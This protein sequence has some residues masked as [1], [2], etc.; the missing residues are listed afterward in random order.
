MKFATALRIPKPSWIMLFNLA[1][2]AVL[3]MVVS[4]KVSHDHQSQIDSAVRASH[5]LV[6][7]VISNRDLS[8]NETIA[9]RHFASQETPVECA[10]WMY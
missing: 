6:R 2:L 3:V 1:I 4:N 8:K 9:P 10:R 5:R 7:A